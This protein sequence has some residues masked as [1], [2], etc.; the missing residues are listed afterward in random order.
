[1]ARKLGWRRTVAYCG[2]FGCAVSA[3]LLY[4][5]PVAT[6]AHMGIALLVC[7]LYGATLAGY[8]PLSALM[9]SL[10]PEH[11]GA[12]MSILNLGAGLS[13]FIGPAI[14][15]LAIGPLG[16]VG[17]IWIFAVLYLLSA[18]LAF[19][20]R[21]P[22]GEPAPA[23]AQHPAA[24]RDIMVTERRSFRKTIRIPFPH[25]K[26]GAPTIT[27]KAN[28]GQLPATQH[29]CVTS[30]SQTRH[31]GVNTPHRPDPTT[32]PLSHIL[33]I[34]ILWA[35][36]DQCGSRWMPGV[37]LVTARLQRIRYRA[38]LAMAVGGVGGG[39]EDTVVELRKDTTRGGPAQGSEHAFAFPG[40]RRLR[41]VRNALKRSPKSGPRNSGGPFFFSVA[42]AVGIRVW[43][44]EDVRREA[45]VSF[46]RQEKCGV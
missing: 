21:L 10:S 26:Y 31:P 25:N 44:H 32:A 23:T 13:T 12:A 42:L 3:L 30:A 37:L 1:M 22:P 43:R 7:V 8:V 38:L 20:L 11:K 27:Q 34:A 5:V 16:I 6:G 36:G 29:P 4:C 40:P 18:I 14:V 17:V 33:P 15:G 2:G 35:L 45:G 39:G 46:S 24:D 9:P 41:C 28:R 19:F